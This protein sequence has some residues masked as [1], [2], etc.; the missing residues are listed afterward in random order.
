MALNFRHKKAKSDTAEEASATPAAAVVD[1]RAGLN[2]HIV[3]ELVGLA[4]KQ[5]TGCLEVVDKGTGQ[6]AHL[7][8]FDGG[9]YSV[10]IDGYEPHV[11]AR[12][13]ASSAI[14]PDALD[15]VGGPDDAKTGV[16]IAQTGA[17]D[18]TR[19][20][21]VHQEYLLA[22]LG[23]VLALKKVKTKVHKG[24]VTDA[25]CTLPLP[26]DP[27]FD[28][29]AR[30]A[31]RSA[32]TSLDGP[33]AAATLALQPTGTTRPGALT[34]PEFAAME[35]GADG[36]TSI[37][38]IARAFGF[39]RAEAVHLAALLIGADVVRAVPA[40][41]A[42]P[43]TLAVPEALG[44]KTAAAAPVVEPEPEPQPIAE[45]V[46]A[47]V[48]V[49]EPEPE[50]ESVIEPDPEPVTEPNVEPEVEPD[51]EPESEA[52]PVLEP[53]P[54]PEPEPVAAPEPQQPV[55]MVDHVLQ[56]RREV[57]SEEVAELEEA[58]REATLA[59]RE[60]IAQAAAIRA[61]LAEARGQL[62]DLES[63]A[64]G[65]DHEAAPDA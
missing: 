45:A 36:A 24:Q 63:A 22:S 57:A 55:V 35:A 48:V 33:A 21:T 8:V 37:D 4:K 61:R 18:P 23:A 53:E 11:G 59:E 27:L 5:A 40:T 50:A 47:A 3:D 26:I 19:L 39:T 9:L 31:E 15:R 38:E 28:V 14:S 20:A 46:V 54:A 44:T 29:L 49:A 62:A 16:R 58:L 17:L 6:T 13:V 32:S 2:A 25:L 56:L 43:G 42:G 7:Y 52:E 30:R 65:A 12:L 60:A 64:D 1:V 41:T 34:L 10:R 51:V